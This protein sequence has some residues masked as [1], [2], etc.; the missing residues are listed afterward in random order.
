MTLPSNWLDLVQVAAEAAVQKSIAATIQPVFQHGI[1]TD[2]DVDTYIHLVQMDGDTDSIP[3]HDI[4]HLGPALGTKVTVLFA[5]PHQAMVIGQPIH[6]PW[7][8]VGAENEPGFATGWANASSSGPLDSD[9]FPELSFRRYGH[10]VE[11]R[12]QVT[13]SAGSTTFFTL[14]EW[15]RPRNDLT[16]A[17]LGP[18]G[19]H[20]VMQ[21]NRVGTCVLPTISGGQEAGF[22]VMFTVS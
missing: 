17:I 1:V 13:R 18:F 15:Y 16:F 3:V 5:P 19:A 9:E 10:L 20:A 2:V 7:H 14:P 12:G 8:F 6:D 4:T 22:S 21:I 11:F